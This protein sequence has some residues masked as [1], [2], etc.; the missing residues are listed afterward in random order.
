MKMIPARPP[1][2]LAITLMIASTVSGALIGLL[3]AWAVHS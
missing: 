1:Q 3:V 2:W